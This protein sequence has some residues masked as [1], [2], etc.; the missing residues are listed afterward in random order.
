LGAVGGG[1]VVYREG[2]QIAL[3]EMPIAGLMSDQAAPV[4]AQKAERL[5]QA[6]AECGCHL[7]NA[8]MQFSLLAL[9]VIPEL[10]ISDLGLVDVREFKFVDVVI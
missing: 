9:V 8:F 10:C 7:H 2:R 4:V 1:V 6:M 5:V 3:I